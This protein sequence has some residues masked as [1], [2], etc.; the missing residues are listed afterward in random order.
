MLRIFLILWCVS[1]SLWADPV[2]PPQ[3]G[4]PYPDLN[5]LDQLG[6]PVRLSS[7]KGKVI[8]VEPVGMSCAACNAFAGGNEKQIGPFPGMS[9]QA[10]LRSFRSLCARYAGNPDL[11]YVQL[12]LYGPTMGVPTLKDAQN[13]ANH[14]K[15][16][17]FGNE[18]VVIGTKSLQNPASYNMIPGFQLID[19]DFT[20][21]V[22][23]TGHN[24]RQDLYRELL[25]R[26]GRLLSTSGPAKPE[27]ATVA[28][29][30]D[31]R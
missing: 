12:L 2:W 16:D 14:F 22:D 13:W 23:S 10:G 29:T 9:A 15:M 27:P 1:L 6:R 8:V 21:L 19:R 31:D 3:T 4:M 28:P 30:P 5:L 11:V 20:L 26:L 24:P 25:P 7:F 18:L 17:R